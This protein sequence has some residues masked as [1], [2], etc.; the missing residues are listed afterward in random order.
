MLP[1]LLT[2]AMVTVSMEHSRP[3]LRISSLMLR[4]LLS[5]ICTPGN[6]SQN[7]SLSSFFMSDGLTYSMMLVCKWGGERCG[8]GTSPHTRHST[9]QY[10][11]VMCT[12]AGQHL[13][14]VDTGHSSASAQVEWSRG[15]NMSAG[16]VSIPSSDPQDPQSTTVAMS[17]TS[18][19]YSDKA[20]LFS[21]VVWYL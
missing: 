2:C 14:Q 16:Y 11:C 20:K 12:P 9:A 13:W 7:F 5:V 19:R 21:Y 15:D 3:I 10:W 6:R 4:S 1:L 17:I 8:A 18:D